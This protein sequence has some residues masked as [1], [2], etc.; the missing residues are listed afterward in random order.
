MT[1]N[2]GDVMTMPI[3]VHF[4]WFGSYWTPQKMAP[5]Q[6][7]VRELGGSD[8]WR[9][10]AQYYGRDGTSVSQNITL[11]TSVFATDSTFL[12]AMLTQQNKLTSDDVAFALRVL[13]PLPLPGD[14]FVFAADPSTLLTV[15]ENGQESRGCQQGGM[16]GYHLSY[17]YQGFYVP[18]IG[19]MHHG[20]TA[21]GCVAC[22]V[23]CNAIRNLPLFP[24]YSTASTLAHELAETATDPNAD[25]WLYNTG[26]VGCPA[27]PAT[28]PATWQQLEV[29]DPCTGSHARQPV[30]AWAN[31]S[32][33]GASHLL[34]DYG[35]YDSASLGGFNV[36][37][38]NGSKYV[39]QQL[40]SGQAGK[41]VSGEPAR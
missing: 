17:F 35:D 22:A 14:I 20:Y 13:F 26:S 36:K 38:A 4:A 5:L 29:G 21:G 25:A 3:T 19:L 41:C 16:C 10:L 34:S 31:A 28:N 33:V 23:P 15:L 2:G 30:P 24:E 27:Q 12:R 1:W 40:W 8:Y 11:G 39:L 37:L 9:T 7:L 32:C 18:Y 6:T